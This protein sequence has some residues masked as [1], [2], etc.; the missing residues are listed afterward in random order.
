MVDMNDIRRLAKNGAFQ[1]TDHVRERLDERGIAQ[2]EAEFV[3]V[4]GEIIEQ[5]PSDYPFASCLVLGA[6]INGHF[7]HVVCAIG[8]EELWM[9]TAYYPDP[10]KWSKDFRFR[11]ENE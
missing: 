6:T 10:K 5:Y 7:M 11:K 4:N 9:I 2:S 8:K 1:W 3:A